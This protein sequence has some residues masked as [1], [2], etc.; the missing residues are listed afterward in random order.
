VSTKVDLELARWLVS[1]ERL[2]KEKAE[3]LLKDYRREQKSEGEGSKSKN[4]LSWLVKLGE[5]DMSQAKEIQK[6]FKDRNLEAKKAPVAEIKTEAVTEVSFESDSEGFTPTFDSDDNP[7][8]E[9]AELEKADEPE[10]EEAEA[11]EEEAPRLSNQKKKCEECLGENGPD[12]KECSFCGSQ[13]KAA[14][15]VD[16]V[17][18]GYKEPVRSKSCSNCGCHPVT[19]RATGKTQ[20]CNNCSTSLKPT[21]AIC[22]SCGT[23]VVRSSASWWGLAGRAMTL[24]QIVV[25]FGVLC[26][27]RLM[28]R[29]EGPIDESRQIVEVRDPWAGL[30]PRGLS[31]NLAEWKLDE[32][33]RPLLE[34]ALQL[35]EAGK[36]KE[37]EDHL[38]EEEDR[39]GIP[40]LVLLGL[41]YFQQNK[42][43]ELLSL[44]KA[45]P[46]NRPLSTMGALWRTWQARLSFR[47]FE[48]TK[49]H[50]IM[51]PVLKGPSPTTE[52]WF[53]GGVMA[54][55]EG[56]TRTAGERFSKSLLG[57]GAPREAHLFLFL[58]NS[59]GPKGKEYLQG[60]IKASEDP[61]AA[62]NLVEIYR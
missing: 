32:E 34:K 29:E 45:L 49:A 7:L 43:P 48:W 55:A 13:L 44:A 20:K 57:E 26:G 42:G 2:P 9:G 41:S 59:K 14:T 31:P 58:L 56:D 25:V 37:A 62:E 38:E 11:E 60:W 17:F 61:K 27:F 30:P 18:C 15:F 3:A 39:V 6:A 10:A 22:L 33:S 46:S 23:P 8:T 24:L 28:M 50:R 54:W 52:Q 40:G 16:C 4:W 12:D 53:W 5:F 19:G 51:E 36:V 21:Q 1:T 35:L 47:E